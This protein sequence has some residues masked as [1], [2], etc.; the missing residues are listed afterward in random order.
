MLVPSLVKIYLVVVER[1][2]FKNRQYI[3]SFSITSSW[4][5]LLSIGRITKKFY[6]ANDA[7]C[8][9]VKKAH[10][11]SEA[12]FKSFQFIFLFIPFRGG[13]SL[14]FE[15]FNLLLKGLCT[16]LRWRSLSRGISIVSDLLSD[17]YF[18]HRLM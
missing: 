3:S 18:T 12:D 15:K 13:Y 9:W 10:N 11:Y 4:K 5:R 1:P 8:F 14:S 7:L 17:N 16:C 2:N 6:P